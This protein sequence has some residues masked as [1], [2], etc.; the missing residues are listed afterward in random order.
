MTEASQ[1]TEEDPLALQTLLRRLAVGFVVLMAG[2]A[3]IF[4]LAAEPLNAVS[5]AFVENFGLLGVFV[6]CL[7]IDATPGLTHEPILVVARQGGIGFWAIFVAA[8]TGSMLSGVL[9]Y[10]IGRVLGG[11]A[12]VQRLLIRYRLREFLH[13]YGVR[14]VAIAALTPFPFA[15]ATWGAGAS[16]ISIRSVLV[17]ALF[18]YPKVLFYLSGIAGVLQFFG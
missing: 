13:R 5:A 16:Q 11:S 2:V 1:A 15:I 8:G 7:L 18:R 14:A 12:F 10:G 9:G 17:G 6:G 4:K 3:V